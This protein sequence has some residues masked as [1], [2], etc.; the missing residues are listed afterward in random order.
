MRWLAVLLIV[1]CARGSG[2]VAERSLIGLDAPLIPGPGLRLAVAGQLAERPVEVLIDL[3]A[4]MTV[5]T[6]GCLEAPMVSATRVKVVDPMGSDEVYQIT[7]LV[8]LTVAGRRLVPFEAGL[9]EGAP[10]MVVLG[11]DRLENTALE[12][13]PSRRVVRFVPAQPKDAWLARAETLAGEVQVLELTKDPQ[14]DWPL[15]PVRLHQGQHAFTGAFLLSTRDRSSRI[16][17][18][19]AKASELKVTSELLD[20]LELP[21]NVEL[22]AE[23]AV[24]QGLIIDQVEL[25]PGVGAQNVSFSVAPG[26]PPLGVAGL[27][28]AD[29]WGRFETA[30]DLGAGVLL[31]HRPRLIAAGDR[32]RC[33]RKDDGL[34]E[35]A[36][37]ELHQAKTGQALSVTTTIWRPLRDGGRVYLDFPGVT[38]ACRVGLTFDAG[39]RG[40]TTQHLFPWARLFETM[41]PCA[42][43]LASAPQA[44]LGLFEDSPLAECPGICA[45]AQDLRTGRVSCECQP[46]PLGLSPEAQ[47]QVLERLR[48]II[49]P[50]PD[51]EP[52][53]PP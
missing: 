7:R 28:A 25:A 39:D 12:I 32:F 16:F 42:E 49:A 11:T 14:H 53:D 20:Q 41:K 31:L 4:S 52:S 9:T 35:D 1:G 30:I 24:F 10:C 29:I 5:V 45:F 3:S 36:C 38:P 18:G 46:G 8:G 27:I 2:P 47:R 50:Q 37:F 43:A 40:R 6:T 17:D 19:L 51:P 34:S 23:L 44:S 21:P 15:L 48:G 22:P 33:A 13:D 26:D